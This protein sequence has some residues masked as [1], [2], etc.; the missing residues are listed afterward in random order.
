MVNTRTYGPTDAVAVTPSDTI[1][2]TTLIRSD[3]APG[4]PFPAGIYVAV[5]GDVKVRLAS[6]NDVTFVNLAA[7]M[8]HGLQFTHV[9]AT[10]TDATGI[11]AL[12][13]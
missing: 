12:F 3:K 4:D 2:N 1:D 7:G 8:M 13:Q 11:I 5:E 9:Y 10:G 6:G